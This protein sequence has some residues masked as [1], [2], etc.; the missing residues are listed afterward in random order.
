M[1]ALSTGPTGAVAVPDGDRAAHAWQMRE[2]IYGHLRSRAVCA[3]AE[4]G[5]AD[6]I[7]GGSPT[8]AEL[9]R[10][11]GADPV[12]LARLLR[13]LVSFGVLRRVAR[14]GVDGF[15]LTPLGETLRS[16]APASALPTALLV[17]T[18]VAP[19]W[20][21]L[22]EVVRR[23]RPAFAEVFGADFFAHLDGDPWLRGVFDRSQETGLSLELEGLLQAVDFAG[24]LTVVDVGGGDGALLTGL[25]QGRPESRG[26]L[27]DLAAALPAAARR[28]AGAGLA[29]RCELVEGDFFTALPSG[30]DRYLLRHILHDWDDDSCRA[31]LGSCR[32]AMGPGARLV[33]VDHLA[34]EPHEDPPDRGPSGQWGAL[35]DLYMMSLFAGGRERTR[36]EVAGLLRE[37]GLTL[38]R[39]TL[40]PGGTGVLEARVGGGPG[41]SGGER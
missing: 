21:R 5:L 7:G 34:D 39:A 11:T 37:A 13:A 12:L 14:E 8:A 38:V 24:P 40:L 16:D 15:G 9:A 27:V 6:T 2:L 19:A 26:V 3:A 1:T 18:A 30:G 35:M 4:L 25:L 36:E 31:V 28:L 17:A 10:A 23:G 41:E 32:R 33:L 20:E 22:T 29:D